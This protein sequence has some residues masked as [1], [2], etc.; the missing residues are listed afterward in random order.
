AVERYQIG[1][2]RMCARVPGGGRGACGRA[3]IADGDRAPAVIPAVAEVDAARE[4]P[5]A[6][7]EPE[8]SAQH[9]ALAR[10]PGVSFVSAKRAGL[11]GYGAANEP[12]RRHLPLEAGLEGPA[13][14]LVSQGGAGAVLVGIAAEGAAPGA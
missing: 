8:R 1:D 4:L 6:V 7:L 13:T 10:N 12:A 2:P 11:I 5:G 9:Q 3:E 14:G